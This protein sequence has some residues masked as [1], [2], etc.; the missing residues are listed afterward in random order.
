MITRR[1]LV[2]LGLMGGAGLALPLGRLQAGLAR[3]RAAARAASPPVEVF[4]VPLPIPPVLE[5]TSSDAET[6]YYEI[7]QREGRVE[8]LP[9]LPTAVWG[10][11]G[12][13]P[14]PTIEARRGRRVAVR[15]RN[16]LPVP[17]STHPGR[18]DAGRAGSE[19]ALR[20]RAVSAALRYR[21]ECRR[22]LHLGIQ[23]HR[24]HTGNCRLL[25]PPGRCPGPRGHRGG[26]GASDPLVQ[27][28]A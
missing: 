20:P 27:A 26:A 6:D 19:P 11:D 22:G 8:I 4:A 28:A 1:Q 18:D 17:V 16:A 13:F 23:P 21:P 15:Q 12:I 10:Y 25:A 7:T 2:K 14:G 3:D 9:G 5:P 24:R